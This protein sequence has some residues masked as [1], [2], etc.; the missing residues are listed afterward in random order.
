MST[1]IGLAE[2]DDVNRWWWVPIACLSISPAA[3]T[4][5]Y[6]AVRLHDR[7]VA[8]LQLYLQVPDGPGRVLAATGWPG[9]NHVRA[10]RGAL[11]EEGQGVDHR[12]GKWKKWLGRR[13]LR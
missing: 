12:R 7:A 10:S 13:C 2:V 5:R 11:M 3:G 6:L 1:D 4:W 8:A 9:S